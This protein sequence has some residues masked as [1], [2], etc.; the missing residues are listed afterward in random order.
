MYLFQFFSFNKFAKLCKFCICLVN[1]VY[2]VWTDVEKN[3]LK[4]F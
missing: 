3:Y 2:G 4:Q 1:M